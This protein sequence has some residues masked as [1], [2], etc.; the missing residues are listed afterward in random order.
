MLSTQTLPRSCRSE[1]GQPPARTLARSLLQHPAHRFPHRLPHVAAVPSPR[2]GHRPL[3]GCRIKPVLSRTPGPEGLISTPHQHLWLPPA[4]DRVSF[5]FLWLPGRCRSHGSNTPVAVPQFGVGFQPHHGGGI[6]TLCRFG[7]DTQEPAFLFLVNGTEMLPQIINLSPTSSALV[8]AHG[9]LYSFHRPAQTI[10]PAGITRLMAKIISSRRGL[11]FIWPEKGLLLSQGTAI[12]VSLCR[13][14]AAPASPR[15][16]NPSEIK[17]CSS[18]PKKYLQAPVF[19]DRS[20][21]STAPA[22]KGRANIPPF[23]PQNPGAVINPP[24]PAPPHTE[25]LHTTESHVFSYHARVHSTRLGV[26]PSDSH[27]KSS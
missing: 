8:T 4:S 14:R 20:C 6:S 10:P 24:R 18:N 2:Q 23:E 19:H 25:P 26:G 11:C 7:A 16:S 15:D 17:I 22:G 13:R 12:L 21:Q 9:S 27:D 1:R 5:S 3:Y